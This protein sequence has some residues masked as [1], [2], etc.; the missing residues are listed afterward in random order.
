MN[1][2]TKEESPEKYWRSLILY[3]ANV[4]TY[5]FA[6]G[7]SLLVLSKNNNQKIHQNDLA[8]EFSRHMCEHLKTGKNQCTNKIS[9]FIDACNAFNINKIS[10][11]QLISETKNTGFRYVLDAFHTLKGGQVTKKF[12]DI[13][14]KGKNRSLI[15]TDY[16]FEL[17]E[18]LQFEN[19]KQEVEARWK[20]VEDT[21]TFGTGS[22]ISPV[23]YDID[24]KD[25]YVDDI[26]TYR[27]N[28]TA[29]KYAFIGYQSGKCFYCFENILVDEKINCD[30]DHFIPFTLRYRINANL[31]G[32]WNLVLSCSNCNRGSNGKLHRI[33]K[34]KY[35]E[36]LNKRNNYL[37]ASNHPLSN[38]IIRQTG[39]D[40]YSRNKFLNK[41]YKNALE[42]IK[43]IWEPMNE[44][45]FSY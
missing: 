45:E 30:V 16:L 21:W 38:T 14:G 15:L 37:I 26:S 42:H 29:A 41:I 5:K 23:S 3:G 34:I 9:S 28:L 35:L 8:I 18:S 10:H 17:A 44:I 19:L 33:P 7:K 39:N 4:A 25:L 36:R 22:S 32:V 24:T 1:T 2:F 13:E 20:L 27:R 43:E 40:D 12:Y 6:L 31:N 11:D